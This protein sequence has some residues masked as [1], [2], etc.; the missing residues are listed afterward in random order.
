MPK[1]F[2]FHRTR[3]ISMNSM[4]WIRIHFLVV[5]LH[6]VELEKCLNLQNQQMKLVSFKYVDNSPW[7]FEVLWMSWAVLKF[8][9]DKYAIKHIVYTPNHCV[10]LSKHSPKNLFGCLTTCDPNV[11]TQSTVHTCILPTCSM[12]ARVL[13]PNESLR[14]VSFQSYSYAITVFSIKLAKH[15]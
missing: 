6:F 13:Q 11:R 3:S 14:Y 2:D 7:L 4:S 15:Q 9:L 10:L 1:S 8:H 12:I 5:H